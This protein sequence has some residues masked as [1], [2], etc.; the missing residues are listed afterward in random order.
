MASSIKQVIRQ[1]TKL[2][3]TIGIKVE[4]AYIFIG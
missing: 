2:F 3:T 1:F 4:Q